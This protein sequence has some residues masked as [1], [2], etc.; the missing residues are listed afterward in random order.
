MAGILNH[1]IV[2]II[3]KTSDDVET[4]LSAFFAPIML[5]DL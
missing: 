1:S 2:Y 4:I 3:E 5:Q